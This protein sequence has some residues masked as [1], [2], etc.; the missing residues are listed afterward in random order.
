MSVLLQESN[1]SL[2]LSQSRSLQSHIKVLSIPPFSQKSNRSL[3]ISF[4]P[5]SQRNSLVCIK[6]SVSGPTQKKVS[7]VLSQSQSLHSHIK[8]ISQS[9]YLFNLSEPAKTRIDISL[10]LSQSRSHKNVFSII[11]LCIQKTLGKHPFIALVKKQIINMI[12]KSWVSLVIW[13]YAKTYTADCKRDIY[14]R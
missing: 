12:R 3:T 8:V 7:L 2:V 5:F 10:V 6:M 4:S 1:I 11:S 14:R 9:H 13:S